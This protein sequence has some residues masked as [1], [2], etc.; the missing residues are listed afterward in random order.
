M[1]TQQVINRNCTIPAV[2]WTVLVSTNSDSSW[3]IS[4]SPSHLW[5]VRVKVAHLTSNA[6]IVSDNFTRIGQIS[7]LG[8]SYAI[9]KS[10]QVH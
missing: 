4:L 7:P 5:G 2:L 6:V 8:Y 1:T 3:L 10:A 9:K